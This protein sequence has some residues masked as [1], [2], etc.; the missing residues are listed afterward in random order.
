MKTLHKNELLTVAGGGNSVEAGK[1]IGE[2]VGALIGFPVAVSLGMPF[3]SASE[4]VFCLIYSTNDTTSFQFVMDSITS[5][6]MN[7]GGLSGEILG[8]GIELAEVKV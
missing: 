2:I 3:F 4:E 8:K 6:S 7:I 5:L 1:A